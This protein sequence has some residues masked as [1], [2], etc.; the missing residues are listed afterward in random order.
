[1]HRGMKALEGVPK[2][3]GSY[4]VAVEHKGEDGGAAIL[5]SCAVAG[6]AVACGG[7]CLVVS[8]A[9][10]DGRQHSIHIRGCMRGLDN[11]PHRSVC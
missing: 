5:G 2:A 10:L 6:E 3:M 8:H 9:E 1:M 4:E 11:D 7:L